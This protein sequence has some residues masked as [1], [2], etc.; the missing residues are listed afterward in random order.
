MNPPVR[1]RPP[2][3]LIVIAATVAGYFAVLANAD[4]HRPEATG[5]VRP[6]NDLHVT[7]VDAGSPADKAGVRVGDRVLATNGRAIRTHHDWLT[8]EA[9]FTP[10]GALTLD[11]EREAKLVRLTLQLRRVAPSFWT[12]STGATLAISRSVQLITLCVALVVV[13]RRPFDHSARIGAWLLASIAVFSIALPWGFA[14]NWRALPGVVALLLWVPYASSHAVT[15][16]MLAFFAGFPRSLRLPPL[17]HL[18]LWLPAVPMLVMQVDDARARVY[19]VS[20]LALSDDWRALI[21]WTPLAYTLAAVVSVALAYRRER[22]VT[23]RRRVRVITFGSAIGLLGFAPIALT[24]ARRNTVA[25]LSVFTS[26]AVA[27]G[28]LISLVAP[29]SFAYAILRHR[30]FDVSFIVRRS[31]QYALARRVLLG[32][33]PLAAGTFLLDLLVNRQVSVSHILQRR[34]WV[35]AGVAVFVAVARLRR[36]SWLDGLDRKFFRERY[37]A[38]RLLRAIAEDVQRAPTLEAAG[39]STVAQIDTALHPT[40]AALMLK[41]AVTRSYECVAAAPA[42]TSVAP[43]PANSTIAGITA[44]S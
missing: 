21:G 41:N 7:R 2:W 43:L 17:A 24:L 30:L 40:V 1:A 44:S 16:I 9:H 23:A 37:N 34:G 3:W 18:A 25:N 5:F 12:T 19:E 35:Y 27:A 10:P 22:D 14:A 33:V 42:D 26:P 39:P 4:I 15:P 38:Q 8:F 32:F 29:A 36:D 20:P 28:T 6:V 11:V 13:W 31:L